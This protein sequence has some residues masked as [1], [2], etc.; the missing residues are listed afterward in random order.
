[1][2]KLVTRSGLL[3]FTV[4]IL[5]SFNTAAETIV[6]AQDGNWKDGPTWA[7]GVVPTSSDSVVVHHIIDIYNLDSCLH[8]YVSSS[9]TIQNKVNSS[10]ILVVKG[11]LYVDGTA[12]YTNNFFYIKLGG[13]LHL[14]GIWSS[15]RVVFTGSANQVVSASPG[16][17]FTATRTGIIFEDADPAS[18]ISFASSLEFS[19]IELSF[20]GATLVFM[21]GILVKVSTKPF[22]DSNIIGNNSSLQLSNGAYINNCSLENLTLKGVFNIG[23]GNTTTGEII[24]ADTLQNLINASRTL[25]VNGNFTNNG[26]IQITNNYLQFTFS[27]NVANNGK[28]TCGNISLDGASQQFLSCGEGKYF[29]CNNFTDTDPGSP[30]HLLEDTEIRKASVD[31][32]GTTL[33]AENYRFVL[34]DNAYIKNSV[35]NNAHLGGIFRVY[36]PQVTFTG[37]TVV[38]DTLQNA[39]YTTN[40]TVLF[41]GLL[42]NNGTINRSNNYGLHMLIAGNLENNAAIN[43]EYVVFSGTSDQILT[44]TAKGNIIE[45][46]NFDDMDEGSKIIVSSTLTLINAVAD[47]NGAIM[48]LDNANLFLSGGQF[49]DGTIE[50]QGNEISQSNAG[51]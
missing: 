10:R 51:S 38:D 25:D 1:M 36:T 30:I 49:E 24:V 22:R 18:P 46:D 15:P 27:G 20:S 2:K 41:E 47:L 19:E 5:I 13:N 12:T 29:Y 31:L 44:S 42:I 14:N 7:G 28:W 21:P 35:L 9:G 32:G 39:P 34:R 11:N 8:L 45:T 40:P 50:A 26:V 16:K 43:S 48:E 37:I 33:D 6:S 17:V 23:F 4:F 3:L